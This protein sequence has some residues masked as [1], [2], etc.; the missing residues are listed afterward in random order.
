VQIL[1]TKLSIPPL[2]SRLVERQ[3][4]M[5]KLDQGMDCGFVLVSA[6]AGY[7][8]STLLSAWLGQCQQRSTWLP[9][10]ES[11]ND[12]PRFLTYLGAALNRIEPGLDKSVEIGLQ[13]SPLSTIDTLLTP[14]V[15]DIARHAQPFY[16]A[17][18]DYHVIQ[19]QSVH[20]AITFLLEHRP[21]CLRLAI[22]TRAD[23]PLP[24]A[25]MRARG[26]I[27]ELRLTDLRFSTS[28]ISEFLC[29]VM[30][31]NLSQAD[32]TLLETS[33][34]GWAAGLQMAGLSLQGRDDV[35]SFIRSFSGE[36]RYV[37]DFLFNE[38][39]QRQPPEL[40]NFLL[41]TSILE[42][43]CGS[44]CD[45]V[46]QR[47]DSQSLLDTLERSNLFLIAIDERREWYR[48]HHLFVDLLKSRLKQTAP[49]IIEF[50][51]QRASVWYAAQNDFENAIAHALAAK[52]YDNAA[53]LIEQVLHKLDLVNQ[54]AQLF[55]WL[56]KLPREILINRPWLCAYRAY[57]YY[58]IGHR[59]M[60][61]E[62]LRAAEESSERT[63]QAGSPEMRHILGFIASVRAHDAIIAENIPYALDMAQT[64]LDL[65]PDGAQCIGDLAT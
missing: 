39:F 43:L 58:W 9:L 18:D 29:K 65:L 36:N 50:L 37:L 54:Q 45:A 6:P 14:L 27:V 26:Q 62:W 53:G 56:D 48:Y 11:D 25:R 4:L 17:L 31:L 64:A 16:L 1:S 55:F 5:Q 61:E 52:E 42:R 23:P 40:Q 33:T 22:A 46:T 34:E 47:K 59:D 3:R 15:N 57:G 38:V 41:Q 28:E 2:R 21:A 30:S 51:H 35:S 32:L 49:E 13:A 60:E 10:D 12:L 24:L 63:Y 8:K 7:G 19:N 20:Q 44:L